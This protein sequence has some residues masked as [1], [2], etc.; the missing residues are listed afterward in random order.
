M[1]ETHGDD[2]AKEKFFPD[3]AAGGC[4]NDLSPLEPIGLPRIGKLKGEMRIYPMR[5]QK[6]KKTKDEADCESNKR[7]RQI[8]PTAEMDLA[9]FRTGSPA[10]VKQS[11][12]GHWENHG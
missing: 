4:G 3:A 6:T 9:G 12:A 11:E 1:K 5:G 2:A 10:V 7:V 8:A